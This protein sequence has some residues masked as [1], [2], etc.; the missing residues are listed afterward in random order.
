MRNEKSP[1]IESE[2]IRIFCFKNGLY[3]QRDGCEQATALTG[4]ERVW[5][6][7]GAGCASKQLRHFISSSAIEQLL[8]DAEKAR[9][10]IPLERVFFGELIGKGAFGVV[11]YAEVGCE[12]SSAGNEPDSGLDSADSSM[13]TTS[14][15]S[16]SCGGDKAIKLSVAAKKLQAETAATSDTFYE[17][18]KELKLMFEVGRHPHIVNLI[19]YTIQDGSLCILT[20]F[21]R[22]GNLK[23]FLRKHAQA[24]TQADAPA[25]CKLDAQRLDLY[26]YQAS[27]RV[28]RI[29]Y[30]NAFNYPNEQI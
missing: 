15:R 22:H 27:K 19:G 25:E 7:E 17:L 20:D 29:V 24:D 21:A 16:S 23:E 30:L 18:F 3:E 1:C 2:I 11:L 10:R 4:G 14:A 8:D 13:K 6:D 5:P 9:W 28:H 12:S 26:A